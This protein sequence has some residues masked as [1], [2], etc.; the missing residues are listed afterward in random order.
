MDGNELLYTLPS[1]EKDLREIMRITRTG[2][3][4]EDGEDDEE[5]SVLHGKFFRG[6]KDKDKDENDD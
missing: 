3:E 1:G 2:E 4:N 5:K 6:D